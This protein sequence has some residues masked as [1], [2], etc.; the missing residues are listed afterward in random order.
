[1]R[2][3]SFC[4]LGLLSTLAIVGCSGAADPSS[5]DTGGQDVTRAAGLAAYYT[6][7]RQDTPQSAPLSINKL[8]LR[9]DGTFRMVVNADVKC[10][11]IDVPEEPGYEC[12]DDHYSN[13]RASY[14]G[15]HGT[16]A[17][18]QGGVL[19]TPKAEPD[20]HIKGSRQ[21][22]TPLKM[23]LNVK[24]GKASASVTIFE[25][26]RDTTFTSELDIDAVYNKAAS[27][28]VA[29]LAGKWNVSIPDDGYDL[30]FDELPYYKPTSHALTIAADGKWTETLD[31]LG[32]D[33]RSDTGALLVAGDLSGTAGTLLL[34]F[35]GTRGY[36]TQRIVSVSRDKIVLKR[37]VA[38][39]LVQKVHSVEITLTRAE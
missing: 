39:S 12:P 33:S 30:M 22:G 36:Y 2:T 13:E 16:W 26:S 32:Q 14:T 3:A 34:R 28:K 8:D 17:A 6:S 25:P 35:E 37:D 5:K 9:L 10:E 24:G 38:S 31:R 18:A 11:S 29:D 1:M 7:Y 23:A 27:T 21:I 20:D 4:V 15:V 19:L